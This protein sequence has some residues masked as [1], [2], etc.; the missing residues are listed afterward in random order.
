MGV[1]ILKT[2]I[3]QSMNGDVQMTQHKIIFV[4]CGSMAY[5]WMDYMKQRE[6][7]EIVALVD[8]YEENAKSLAKKFDVNAPVYVDLEEALEKHEA[9]IVV[10]ITIPASRKKIV[11]T[12]LRAGCHVFSEKP[13]AESFQEAQEILGVVQETGKK[14]FIM[15][16]RRFLK[17]VR[18]IQDFL[19]AGKIGNIGSIHAH[20]FLGP[21]F[22]GFREE[23]D[24]PLIL[25]MAI[26]T[27]DQA[28]YMTNAQPISVYCHEYNPSGSWYEG[29]ASASCIFEMSNGMIF[30]YNGSWCAQGRQTS[31]E[32]D[33]RI[34]GS[35]GSLTWDG[36]SDITSEIVVDQGNQFES[37]FQKV[38]VPNIWDGAEEHAGCLDEM[39][40]A[41][42]EKRPAETDCTDNFQSISMVFG[43][44][45][46]AKTG[47]KVYIAD[48]HEKFSPDK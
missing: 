42:T 26:H 25:D 47:K 16:N 24:H 34:T 18:S 44:I 27:F 4:G 11:T 46:S 40:A 9:N 23:M 3:N 1:F 10:D 29:N 12:A 45:E 41:L 36:F 37:T 22:G 13:M 35:K 19:T 38:D 5:V 30:T 28:R 20:F 48:L 32:A 33:W 17:Q 39:F 2:A 7:V 31:W 14:Y 21:H 8:L 15:Q 6:D 43:A